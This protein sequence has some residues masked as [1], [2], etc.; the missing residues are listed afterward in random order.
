M[1]EA[2]F[3]AF[4]GLF[5]SG[6]GVL[7]LAAIAGAIFI[8]WDWRIA[9]AGAFL[10]HLGSSSVLVAIHHVPGLLAAGQMMA[11]TLSLAIL[12]VSGI[13]QSSSLTTRQAANWP[14]RLM[15]LL[16][17]TGAW[18]FLDTGYALP[19][20]SKME[21]DLL[22]WTA[23]CGLALWSFSSSPLMAGVAVL[24]WS[25]P[26]Y[27]LASVLL[28]GSGLTA[29]IGIADLILA[30]ACGYLILLEPAARATIARRPALQWMV[31]AAEYVRRQLRQVAATEQTDPSSRGG[32]VATDPLREKAV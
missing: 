27:A 31:Q 23:L 9:L 29:M 32:N 17:I 22:V 15:A 14:L 7:L 19:L 3:T 24:I 16:F 13:L 10:L 25:T 4:G 12:A 1:I 2:I 21:T 5:A 6:L 20:F 8:L 26:L 18:W 11:I 30:L 28:P